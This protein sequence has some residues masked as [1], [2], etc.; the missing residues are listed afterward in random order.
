MRAAIYRH[1]G[2]SSALEITQVPTPEPGPGEVRV[3]IAVS[4]VNPTDWK[5]LRNAGEPEG[6]FAVPHQDGAGV[7]DA[8]GA[9]VSPDR[10]GERVWLL[11]AARDRRWGTAAEYSVVPAERAVPLPER[12]SFDLGA[13]LGVPAVTAWHCLHTDGPLQDLSVL[14]SGGA[15]A[16]GN[17]AI[18]LARWAG[19]A[20][21]IATV[22]NAEKGELARAAGAD[23]VVN[24]REA[25]AAEQ[26]RELSPDG[27]DRIVEVALDANLELDL[28]VTAPHAVICSYA[29]TP[30]TRAALPVREL[31]AQ[32]ISLRFMLLY[33]I[34]SAE[35]SAAIT[36]VSEAVSDGALPL[37]PL[38]RYEL[39]QIAA[40][41]DAVEAGAVGKVLID[42]A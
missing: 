40:A 42:L 16:V 31:M 35:L 38:H 6:G 18:A 17:M 41:Q 15:G 29:A 9:G 12:A 39:E 23:H 36:A 24:Y 32:N 28:A 21:V 13:S 2:G 8:V 10:V 37:L 1:G 34:R 33:T 11:M 4:G 5:S 20:Q 3:R 7:I 19:A 14:V 22:S 30:E 26:I 27:I 25:T